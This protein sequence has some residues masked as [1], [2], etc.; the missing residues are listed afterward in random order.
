MSGEP[1]LRKDSQSI[2]FEGRSQIFIQLS[3][4]ELCDSKLS[5]LHAFDNTAIIH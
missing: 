4:I 1:D 5:D 2:K 3:F